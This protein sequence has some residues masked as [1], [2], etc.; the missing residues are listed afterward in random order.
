MDI[1]GILMKGLII[2]S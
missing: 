2:S 1:V